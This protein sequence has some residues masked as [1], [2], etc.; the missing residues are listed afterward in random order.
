MQ[1]ADQQSGGS[2]E[3]LDRGN[4]GLGETVSQ[5][6]PSLEKR[7]W[8]SKVPSGELYRERQGD[9]ACAD[10]L[11]VLSSLRKDTVDIVFLDPPFNLGKVYGRRAKRADQLSEAKYY[12]YMKQILEKSVAALKPGGALYL[13]HLPRWAVRFASVLH[14][15]LNFR[16]WIAISMKN[17]FARGKRLYPAHYALLYYTKGEPARFRRPKTPAPKC[18][19]C[20]NYLKDYGGYKRF[21]R[22]GINLSDVWDDLSPVRHKKY[23][24]RNSNE[25]PPQILRRVLTISGTHKG[26]FVDPFAG[27]GT[28]IAVA[29]DAKMNFVAGDREKEHCNIIRSRIKNS[30]GKEGIKNGG[31]G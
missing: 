29:L 3:K 25:L 17:N 27:T 2:E 14:E 4:I 18:R 19:H 10:A 21:I 11:E 23:K 12:D 30:S 31:R 24:H 28:S 22:R 15:T 13:Y 26:L 1:W 6:I 5:K 7:R 8:W 16:H 20:K 9:I